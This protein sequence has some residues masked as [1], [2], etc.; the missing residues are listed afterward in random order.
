MPL[1]GVL[2]L[3]HF[4]NQEDTDPI[5]AIITQDPS[6]CVTWDT[7]LTRAINK[8][9][10]SHHLTS[11]CVGPHGAFMGVLP[12]N[13]AMAQGINMMDTMSLLCCQASSQ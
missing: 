2:R 11:H 13:D 7:L 10:V 1:L 5:A 3:H 8:P 12:G 4:I 6:L 9:G